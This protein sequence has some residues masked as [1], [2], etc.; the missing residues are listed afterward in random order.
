MGIKYNELTKKWDVTYHKRHPATRVPHRAGKKGLKTQAEA[1]RAERELVILIEERFRAK[2]IPTWSVFVERYKSEATQ[3]GILC[4]KSVQDY[5][6][7]LKAHTFETW[8]HRLIDTITTQEIRDLI[9]SKVGHRS[10]SHQKSVLKMIRGVFKHAVDSGVLDRE[11]TPKMH[12]RTGDK[13]KQ[14]LTEP[15]VRTLLEKARDLDWEW[16]PHVTTAVYTGMRNGELFALTWDKVNLADRRMLVDS[17]WN[18][19][20]GFKSTKS[21]NDR[22]VEIAAPLIPMLSELKLRNPESTFVLPRLSDWER[23]CQARELRM[24]LTGIGLPRIRFHDLRATWATLMLGK[25]VEPIKVM[26][27]G[28][29]NDMK[30]MLVYMRKA[31]IDIQGITDVLTLHNPF[32]EG[33]KVLEFRPA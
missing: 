26:K 3:Q 25:G 13:I 12:F 32:R 28:G 10:P 15:Q 8:Q 5:Y 7:C 27:M 18:A 22:I 21:G 6:A 30:T 9:K 17:S 2:I 23:G 20:N 1:R 4:L 14:C 16:Y 33:A 31:G 24:F 19:I 11:P 29:W